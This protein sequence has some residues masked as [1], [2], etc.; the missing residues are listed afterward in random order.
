MGT[1]RAPV[2]S[3]FGLSNAVFVVGAASTPRF[4]TAAS[5][6]HVGTTFH[7]RLSEAARVRI[8][9]AR[10]L[11]GGRKT[12]IVG[13]LTQVSH[14]GLNRVG[15]SGRIGSRPLKPGRYQATLV[16]TSAN[17]QR[18]RPHTTRFTIVKR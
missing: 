5:A 6:A 9:I 4:G 11:S 13:A 12:R 16:A 18:S 14:R 7:Y 17:Q 10:R 3:R 8:T 1:A 2:V 15:F